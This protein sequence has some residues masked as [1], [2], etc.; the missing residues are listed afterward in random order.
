MW[1]SS[2]FGAVGES[3]RVARIRIRQFHLSSTTTLFG[4][5]KQTPYTHEKC[6]SMD[7]LQVHSGKINNTFKSVLYLFE[8]LYTGKVEGNAN[9]Q[10]IFI[11]PVELL[12]GRVNEDIV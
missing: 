11:L 5:D 3:S 6:L 1:S 2:I 9:T 7:Q 4:V 10:R 8:I 12:L